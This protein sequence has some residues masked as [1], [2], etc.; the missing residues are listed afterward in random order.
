MDEPLIVVV[1]DQPDMGGF[2]C[3]VAEEMGFQSLLVTSVAEFQKIY[4]S[5]NPTGIVVD[6]VM[7]DMDGNE[8]LNWLAS[9][10]SCTPVIIVSGYD[11]RYLK[12]TETLAS[13]GGAIVVGS[14]TKP[15]SVSDLKLLLGQLVD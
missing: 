3:D 8:L 9:Q 4:P 7:P 11:G 10:N 1:D 5:I 6:I 14:L 13:Q 2:V 15:Y 12:F